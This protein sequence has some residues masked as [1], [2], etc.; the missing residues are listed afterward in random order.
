MNAYIRFKLALTEDT[1][2]IK[3]Y[4]EDRWAKLPDVEVDASGE[5]QWLLMD[6]LTNRWVHLLRSMQ[7]ADWK[8]PFN[9]P[10]LGVVA[11]GE[12]PRVVFMAWSPSH[13]PD[14]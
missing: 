11:A 1:P 9:H 13:R 12:K 8:R 10:E 2:T 14:Y 3:P 4:M 5:F 7:P 6:T